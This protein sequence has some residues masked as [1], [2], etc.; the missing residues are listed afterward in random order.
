MPRNVFYCEN[1][2]FSLC[3]RATTGLWGW[4]GRVQADCGLGVPCGVN[5]AVS[6]GQ[7]SSLAKCLRGHLSERAGIVMWAIVGEGLGLEEELYS[8][9]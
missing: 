5:R 9:L 3:L 2:S 1:H 6:R 8:V 4:G 7:P